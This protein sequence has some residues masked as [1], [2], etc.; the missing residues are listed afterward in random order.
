LSF[1]GKAS[2]F[3]KLLPK[4]EAGILEKAVVGKIIFNLI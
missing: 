1:K 3:L 2:K 4:H